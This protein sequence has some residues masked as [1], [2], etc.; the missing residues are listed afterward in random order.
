[1]GTKMS[2]ISLA[3]ILWKL[4]DNNSKILKF[5]IPSSYY[6]LDCNTYFLS[7]KY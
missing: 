4:H 1:M 6:I 3:T 5:N 2:N 7:L